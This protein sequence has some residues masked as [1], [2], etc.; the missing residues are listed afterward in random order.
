MELSAEPVYND[1]TIG[2]LL[3]MHSPELGHAQPEPAEGQK[4]RTR[5]AQGPYPWGTSW[6][7]SFNLNLP[8][9]VGQQRGE[10]K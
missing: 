4:S 9:L 2:C 1:P 6:I 7:P 5:Q 10:K 8:V 3:P